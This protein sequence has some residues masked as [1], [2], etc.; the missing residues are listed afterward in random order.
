MKLTYKYRIYP[1][2]S[3]VTKI[4]NIFSM[5]RHLY[6][7]NL[8]QRIE[9]YEK[10]KRTVTY[11]EQQNALPALKKER[12]LF[13]AVYSQ[14]LQDTL[15]RLDKAFQKFFSQKKGFPKYKKRGQW[16]SI[17][18]PQYQDRPENGQITVPK[19][20]KIKLVYHR[21]LPEEAEIK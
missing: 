2:A 6:N 1:Q 17:T 21:P 3:Q 11:R 5:C 18:Y 14:V 19:V 7:W 8:S 4:K 15:Q 20:G 13:T 10:E 16:N 12:S 9:V